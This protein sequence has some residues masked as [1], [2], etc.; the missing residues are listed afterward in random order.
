MNIETEYQRYLLK[1]SIDYTI[2]KHSILLYG[3]VVLVL[4]VVFTLVS[5]LTESVLFLV[6]PA[7]LLIFYIPFACGNIMRM[8][9]ITRKNNDWIICESVLSNPQ[10][11][12]NATIYFTLKIKDSNNDCVELTTKAIGST[13]GIVRPHFSDLNNRKV[14]VACNLLTDD[15]V[16]L[17]LL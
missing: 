12:F 15:V 17:K 2:Y 11:S 5:I 10:P 9:N 16:V 8:A 7:L 3:I 6:V 1:K 13:R 14:L 4:I